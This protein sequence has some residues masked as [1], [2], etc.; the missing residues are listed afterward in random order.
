MRFYGGFSTEDL[1]WLTWLECEEYL[2]F[3]Q[4]KENERRALFVVD[5]SMAMRSEPKRID[6]HIKALIPEQR[7]QENNIDDQFRGVTFEQ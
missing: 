5:V 2:E 1:E 4:K 7:A 3:Y 6:K